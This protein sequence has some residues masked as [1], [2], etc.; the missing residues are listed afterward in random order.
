MRFEHVRGEV[1]EDWL[2]YCAF[3]A[4]GASWARKPGD[5]W[6]N[7]GQK[8]RFINWLPCPTDINRR[9]AGFSIGRLMLFVAGGQ[10]HKED[11]HD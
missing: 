7:D 3:G 9:G 11:T 8:P 4:V 10:R 1:T 2:I 5:W 6:Y